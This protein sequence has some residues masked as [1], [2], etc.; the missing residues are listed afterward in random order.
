VS[1]NLVLITIFILFSAAT[2]YIAHLFKA[3]Q[4]LLHTQKLYEQM[5]YTITNEVDTLIMEK[6][7]ATLTIAMSVAQNPKI[8]S[9]LES[10][11][12]DKQFFVN[13]SAKLRKESDFKNVWFQLVDAKGISLMRSWTTLQGVDLTHIRFDVA[14]ML[15]NPRIMTTISVGEFD[16]TFK[17][18]VPLHNNEGKFVGFLE[19]ITHFNS[20]AKKLKTKG[21][22]TIV[23]VN[24]TY[25]EL[26]KYPFTGHF[27]GDYY[28]AN[29]DVDAKTQEFVTAH[30]VDTFIKVQTNYHVQS[31]IGQ[32]VVN[33]P[34]FTIER[35]P[36]ANVM[37]FYPIENLSSQN[38]YT[39][40]LSINLGAFIVIITLGFI[41]SWFTKSNKIKAISPPKTHRIVLILALLFLFLSTLYYGLLWYY[42]QAKEREYLMV[43]ERNLY[44]DYTI[45]YEK[46]RTIANT[47]FFT[48]V[49]TPQVHALMDEAS[50]PLQK[51]H[52]RQKL[53]D[54]LLKTYD[55]FATHNLRQ[56][57]FQLPNNES[58]LR[59]HRPN[60]FGDNLTGV[61][62]TI[63]YVNAQLK[64]IDGFEEGRIY[65]GFRYVWPLITTNANEEKKHLGSVEIS[66]SVLAF[67][68]DF[69][70]SH[71]TK[72]TFLIDQTTVDSKVFVDEQSN[73]MPSPFKGF[74]Y[75][76]SINEALAHNH[77]FFDI[78]QI[79]AQQGDEL[80]L[81]VNQ[82]RITTI[83][84]AD[85]RTL[86]TFL[87]IVNP[88]TKVAVA[89]IAL[90]TNDTILFDQYRAFVTFFILGVLIIG[91]LLLF[92]YYEMYLKLVYMTLSNKTQQIIDGQNA[93]VLI[94]DGE[95]IVDAN[96]KLLEYFGT[97]TLD[98]FIAHYGCISRTFI[99]QKGYFWVSTPIEPWT[100]TILHMEDKE[101]IVL[102]AN[103]L[104][105]KHSFS[106][107]IN[108]FG[109]NFIVT[110]T[111]ISQTVHE[112]FSLSHRAT[113]DTLTGAYNREY[114]HQHS[115]EF[116]HFAY[117]N[118][119]YASL[120]IFDI[121]HFKP[122]NDTFGHNRGDVILQELVLLI[123]SLLD[124]QKDMLVRWGGEEFLLLS[125]IASPDVVSQKSHMLR[126]LIE[127]H[128]FEEV[129]RVTC[130]FGVALCQRDEAI[131]STIERADKALYRAKE[132]GRNRLEEAM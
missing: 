101:R 72:S 111:D 93:I 26:I 8:L 130:S 120:T 21:I 75:E 112:Q 97:P 24:P 62:N 55:Y 67:L 35:K 52:A 11:T 123:Q 34:L 69:A 83:V 127:S 22:A 14:S 42:F 109:S 66:Y 82:N 113:H 40:N 6:K 12:P 118:N 9:F 104:G 59:F 121:D 106:V 100:Q 45:I 110:L 79:D 39:L 56:L 43:H 71:R 87:P 27:I 102:I 81:L 126:N 53:H 48:M 30:G 78:A 28:I 36:M 90:Q 50:D 5:A 119:A 15:D 65:N 92:I 17:A 122:I 60:R 114:F 25:K 68:E 77:Q 85:R 23:A 57:H 86:T 131:L 115:Q 38:P 95:R 33:Y 125:Y 2:L 58:F 29:F 1:R 128:H 94:S 116:I 105:E 32:L 70:L 91:L 51:K 31:T 63:E 132:G 84:S 108:T 98:T 61:R 73:Y 96:R 107:N 41:L 124:P 7:N 20:I 16:M 37:L 74:Y 19:A 64:P 117:A 10:K 3:S 4:H 13:F 76:K 99:P 80:W 88:V 54:A 129:G 18:M 103:H 44:K 49:N 89:A 47:L 46:Y